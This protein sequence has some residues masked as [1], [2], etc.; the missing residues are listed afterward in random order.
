MNTLKTP[1]GA[2]TI[3]N[4]VNDRRVVRVTMYL[5]PVAVRPLCF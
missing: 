4:G 5:P 2:A 1:Y 3:D